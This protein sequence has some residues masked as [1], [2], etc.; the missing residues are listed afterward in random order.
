M[1]YGI[2]LKNLYSVTFSLSLFNKHLYIYSVLYLTRTLLDIGYTV[3]KKKQITKNNVLHTQNLQ[4]TCLSVNELTKNPD[5][6]Q[7]KLRGNSLF[8][9]HTSNTSKMLFFQQVYLI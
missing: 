1:L 3:I 8:T 6:H 4:L 2:I 9:S 7:I 5:S